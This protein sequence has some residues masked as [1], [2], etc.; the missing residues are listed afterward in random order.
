MFQHKGFIGK[1]EI[2]EDEKMLVGNVINLA[3]DGITFA[4]KT[5]EEAEEDFRGAVDDYL[6]WAEEEGF[7]AEKPYQGNILVRA[8]PELHREAA[9]ASALLGVSLNNF[10][11]DAIREKLNELIS[12]K[13]V[14]A[15]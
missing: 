14:T 2:D 12:E 1:V 10:V 13:R 8:A 3:K 6:A 11:I 9:T 7:E 5:V 15:E 4:G